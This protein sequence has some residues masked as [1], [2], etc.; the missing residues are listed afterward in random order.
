[1]LA[2]V[3][4]VAKGTREWCVRVC[5]CAG[6]LGICHISPGG[7]T[8][9]FRSVTTLVGLC[10]Q[11]EACLRCPS[12]SFDWSQLTRYHASPPIIFLQQQW[13]V[14]SPY[15]ARWRRVV[16]V[17]LVPVEAWP[18]VQ[19]SIDVGCSTLCVGACM[20]ALGVG[21]CSRPCSAGGTAL[22]LSAGL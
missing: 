1:M 14:A 7:T 16:W 20:Q 8:A 10:R 4:H 22:L 3:M 2:V 13:L 19:Q 5:M 6:L 17:R 11:C 15:Q 12:P 21:L 18:F 9:V